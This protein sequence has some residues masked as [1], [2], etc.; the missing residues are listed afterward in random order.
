MTELDA[1]AR[2]IRQRS[3]KSPNGCLEWQGAKSAAGYGVM[4]YAGRQRGV[5]R[6]MLAAKLKDPSILEPCPTEGVTARYAL[7]SCD[8]RV[9]CN[10]A[11]L[12]L[13]T[14]QD[15]GD[16]KRE[17]E[18][19]G[20]NPNLPRKLDDASVREIRAAGQTWEGMCDMMKKHKI[21]QA[22]IQDVIRGKTYKHVT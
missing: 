7:H 10:P 2:K 8:N 19:H 22:S 6:I 21:S 9:C 20:F 5:H 12:R 4:R 17:R 13:G 1:I 16:D 14:P 15:N 18:R 3:V 11:H